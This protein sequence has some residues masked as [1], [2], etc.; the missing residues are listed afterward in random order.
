MESSSGPRD[1]GTRPTHKYNG[2]VSQTRR[3]VAWPH[4][5][6]PGLLETS[7]RKFPLTMIRGPPSS[8][9]S[10]SRH[11]PSRST[12]MTQNWDDARQDQPPP[13]RRGRKGIAV[14]WPFQSIATDTM[15]IFT[16]H[17]PEV[18][19]R[20]TVQVPK[21]GVENDTTPGTRDSTL[22]PDYVVNFIRGETPETVA[23][24][25]QNGGNQGLRAVD[26]THQH[27]HQRSHMALLEGVNENEAR[28]AYDAM[29]NFTWSS[30][31]TQ[32]QQMLP[33]ANEKPGMRGRLVSGWR[34]GVFVNILL[35]LIILITG[36]IC[37][38]L[39]G[40]KKAGLA[41]EMDLF[42][43]SCQGARNM[44][45][46]LHALISVFVLILIV[47][48]NYVFQVLS[49]PTRSEVSRAHNRKQWLEIGV[50][51][52]RNFKHI[53]KGRVALA[54]ILLAVAVATQIM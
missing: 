2:S 40:T 3:L 53:G 52:V 12:T 18:F 9:G 15:S 47:G 38:V 35:T 6:L 50:P 43:G 46:G 16:S 14:H 33:W 48:A 42:T 28:R 37:V 49:S 54:I 7:I 45:W 5:L 11:L 34:F 32:L 39:A 44:D 30:T 22:I 8:F 31:M 27:R 21:R 1:E 23:R 41:G 51:S 13:S 17:T 20:T 26:I 10:M 24:R 4:I 29:S 19:R 36:F 25:K